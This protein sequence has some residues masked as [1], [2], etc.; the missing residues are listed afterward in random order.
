MRS[1]L[2]ALALCLFVGVPAFAQMETATLSGVIQDPKGAVVPDVEVTATRI[3]TGTVVTI[4]T[5]GAGIYVFTSLMPGHYHL[6][7]HGLGFKEIVIKEFELHVQD[8]LEQNFALEI[9]SVL[10]TV[11]VTASGLN[12]STTDSSVS[13]VVDHTYVENMPLNG[14]SFQDLILLTPGVVTNTPQFGASNGAQAVGTTGEFS[15][16]GQRTESNYYMVDGV[17]ANIGVYPG[18]TTGTQNSGSLPA[19]TALGTTQALVSVDA[20]Q[21]FRIQT[22]TY[23]AEYGRNPGGQFSMVTRSGTNQWHG[24]AFDYLR[25]DYFDANNWFNDFYGKPKPPLRQNDFGGTLG[26]PV[27]IPHVYNGKDKTFFF[28]SYEGLRLLQPQAANLNYVPDI[29]LRQSTPAPL[30]AVMN[31]FPLPNG[32]DLG[33]GLAEFIGTWPNPSSLD[34]YSIRLDQNFSDKLKVFFRFS[35]TPSEGQ[36]RT[37]S[38]GGGTPS[39]VQTF[40]FKPRTYT[41]GATSAF[42]IRLNNEFRFNYSSNSSALSVGLD[43]FGGAQPV[44]LAQLQGISQSST[45]YTIQ[46]GLYFG[47]YGAELTQEHVTGLQRQW[48]VTDALGISLG[49]HQLKFGIDY[50][51]IAPIQKPGILFAYDFFQSADVQANNPGVSAIINQA[52]AYP[53]YTNFSAFAQD[54]WKVTPR[55]ALSMGLRWEVNPPPGSTQGD[56]PYTA[57]GS[58][59]ATLALAPQGTPLWK[60]D[61]FNFAPR[62]GATYVLRDA[63]GW[64]T[65]VRGGGGVF[66]DTGQQL[67]STG[68]GGVGFAGFLFEGYFEGVP[69]S[70]PIPPAEAPPALSTPT[71]PYDNIA[72]VFPSHYQL[73]YTLQWNVALQQALGKAQSLSATYV[74]SHGARLLEIKEIEASSVNPSFPYGVDLFPNGLTSDYD[75]L[76]LQFKRSLSRGLTALASYTFSH[77]IDYG[78][79]D[80]LQPYVRG[81]SDFD[82]RHSFSSALSYNL[83]NVSTNRVA[84]AVLNNWGLDDRFSARSG[85]PVTLNGLETV[86]PNTGQEYFQGLNLNPGVSLY[87]SGSDCQGCPGGRRINPAAFSF[88]A[89]GEPGDV[90]RNFVRAFGAW[91][92]DMAVR[93]EFPIYERLKLQFRAEAFNIFNHPNF[94]NIDPYLQDAKTTFGEANATLNASLGTLSPLYQ[95][96]GPRSMQFALKLIF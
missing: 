8:K 20:L 6:L 70:F 84:R 25:N 93:R 57:V 79:R 60:T 35:N 9:G 36:S 46:A 94:G 14:R 90:P 31:A 69:S 81:N 91:Q 85:F 62:L 53:L 22:S 50:R 40:E 67:G 72:M 75:A 88:P 66:F 77:S 1:L 45:A 87:L 17:S 65:V 59:L 24:S 13:T 11:T 52:S 63:P 76:Q 89:A 37:T 56:I 71:P 4:K 15:V 43:N 49:R 73:P 58:S 51:R 16:N 47:N 74:G 10:E 83:P 44:D 68:F 2:A 95:M 21:E 41:F 80:N 92:M 19:S 61:W 30:Q 18:D 7:I 34:A 32:P 96:G 42:S 48:N 86:N 39:T 33:N 54:E 26:G 55:L 12:V 3:E 29:A 64:E 5:N 38:A 82:V 27:R 28:F 78:S 23:S